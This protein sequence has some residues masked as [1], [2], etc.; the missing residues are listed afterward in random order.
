M[1]GLTRR[2][3]R[4]RFRE[5]TRLYL[6]GDYKVL[7]VAQLKNSVRSEIWHGWGWNAAKR[8]EFAKRRNE[9]AEAAQRQLAACRVFVTEVDL[10]GRVPERLV[11]GGDHEMPVCNDCA[12][13]RR[14]RQRHDARPKWDSEEPISVCNA[15]G[16]KLLGLPERLSIY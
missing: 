14:A 11:R 4:K 15:C 1:A 5:H 12:V 9:I 3:F 13:L 8:A 16:S 2:L 7:D 6:S 10:Q